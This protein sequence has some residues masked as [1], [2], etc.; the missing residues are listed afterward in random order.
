MGTLWVR[1]VDAATGEPV[2]S[3]IHL[4]ASDGKFYAPVDAYARVSSQGDALF[5]QAGSF[6]V[7][8]P[9]GP[10]RFDAVKGFEYYPKRTAV[11]V[12]A[13]E[14]REVTVALERMTDMAARGW[15]SG[16]THVHMNYGGN[17]HNT[18]ENLLMMSEAEG[19]DVVN[20]QIANKDNRI[21]D[22]Q[23]F[24]PG[25][26]A[27]PLST[28]KRVLVVGQE[29]RPPF[30][31][32][33]FFFGLRDHL[34]SPFTT[35]YEGTGVESLYPSNTDMFRKAKAQGATVGYVH[36]FGGESDPLEG[37]LGGAKGYIVDAALGTTDAVEWSDSSRA[38]FFPWYATLN[39]GLRVTAVGGEDSISS[40]QRSK[41]VGS[42]RT[43]VHT[44]DRGLTMEAWFDGLRK[45]NAF[46]TNGPLV[47]LT[48][49]GRL[50]GE[51]VALP[52]SGGEVEVEAHVSSIAPLDRVFL[53]SNGEEIESI[54]LAADR[55]S[56]TLRKKIAVRNPGWYHLRAEG[57]PE[58]R[59]P[60][61]AAYAQAFTNPV[62]VTVGG[63]E[64]RDTASAQYSLRWID[65]L[66]QMAEA[67][68][69]WRSEKEKAHVFAQFDDARAVYRRLASEG[70]GSR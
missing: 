59:Y 21:L 65:K 47:E 37:D 57:L 13:G 64:P 20:E 3:R 56:A 62:W 12:E 29:Y 18:L 39:N 40:L 11:T 27:H 35:G 15:Y 49:D 31:G 25:G 19:Q 8:V 17:L 32:H 38:G 30:Y 22:Y 66:Q 10:V 2:G 53:V 34:I 48:L 51:T 69:H 33:V 61:D 42:F 67:W 54:P 14:V 68:P 1:T 9:S 58:E 6:R 52:A 46:V 45:G 26:G 70:T 4:T 28:S 43:Y 7:E 16:S 23:Y 5:H 60:F 50:P 41:L 55:K 63:R 36:A 44:G 24:V